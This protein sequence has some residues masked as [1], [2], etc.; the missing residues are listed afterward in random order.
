MA[1]SRVGKAYKA[2]RSEKRRRAPEASKKLDKMLEEIQKI[3]SVCSAASPDM[4]D[5]THKGCESKGRLS[6]RGPTSRSRRNLSP[7]SSF[8]RLER[9][10]G[11]IRKGLH[12]IRSPSLF[13]RARSPLQQKRTGPENKLAQLKAKVALLSAKYKA[14]PPDLLCVIS[15]GQDRRM[16]FSRGGGQICC[17]SQRVEV[18]ALSLAVEKHRSLMLLLNESE[19][20]T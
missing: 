15:E 9:D 3:A 19:C 7:G 14:N 8:S 18:P 12:T 16:N 17:D 10:L 6:K 20:T 5:T 11:S 1:P 13:H 4:V 2:R